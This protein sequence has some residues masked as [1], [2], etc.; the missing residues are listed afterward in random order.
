MTYNLYMVCVSN[1]SDFLHEN[2]MKIETGHAP[3]Q[4][5]LWQFHHSSNKREP[6][7]NNMPG[8]E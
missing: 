8:Q 4:T 7:V 1:R 3:G 2:Q 5:E 6:N